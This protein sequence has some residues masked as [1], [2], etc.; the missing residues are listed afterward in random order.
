MPSEVIIINNNTSYGEGEY[1]D[2]SE[3]KE[4]TELT[5][6]EINISDETNN[7]KNYNN[8]C[9]IEIKNINEELSFN[10]I[11]KYINDYLNNNPDIRIIY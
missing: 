8:K 2:K 1:S 11:E 6:E 7:D 4:Q 9:Q 3:Y 10:T 5:D